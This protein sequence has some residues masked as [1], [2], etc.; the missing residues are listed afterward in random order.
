VPTIIFL[1]VMTIFPLIFSLGVSFTDYGLGRAPV[2]VG[3]RNYAAFLGDPLFW[4]AALNTLLITLGAVGIEVALGLA[5]A[6]LF[7]RPLPGG[8]LFRVCL[9]IP[10]MI[11]PLVVGFFW[12]F[13]FDE[14]FGIVNYA[15]QSLG[16][17]S[18]SWL[19]HPTRA[20]M[21]III[22]D[23]WQWTPFVFLLTL[24]GLR[25]VP[26]ELYEAAG[27][28]K[29]SSWLQFRSITLPYIRFPL[30]LALLF[31]MIDTIKIFD[32]VYIMT[33]GGPGDATITLSVLTYRYGFM[34]YQVG[35]AAALSWLAV[36]VINILATV[37]IK[38]LATNRREE[39]A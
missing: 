11:S 12:K 7:M 30:L 25:T 10:M 33:G 23:V 31:R 32:L 34:F 27:L 24:A 13:M 35:K 6:L 15:I 36:I 14:I 17:P 29:A 1:V 9:F 22:V 4:H 16:G 28:E 20:L 21:A 18:F 19:T 5:L 26:Q 37:L 38:L 8:G 3:V 2:F 39:A